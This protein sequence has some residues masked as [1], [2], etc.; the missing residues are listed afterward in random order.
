MCFGCLCEM[1]SFHS[2]VHF[3]LRMDFLVLVGRVHW[4]KSS[5]ELFEFSDA[6]F[7]LC[8]HVRKLSLPQISRRGYFGGCVHKYK[9]KHTCEWIS[10]NWSGALSQRLQRSRPAKDHNFALGRVCISRI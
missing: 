2:D 6:A 1:L 4:Y 3:D 7:P 8:E 9:H 5:R 10:K